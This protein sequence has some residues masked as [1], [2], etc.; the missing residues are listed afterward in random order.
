M[1]AQ[2]IPLRNTADHWLV[3]GDSGQELEIA[4][5]T[6]RVV[7]VEAVDHEPMILTYGLRAIPSMVVVTLERAD[8][9]VVV[10]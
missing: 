1:T 2:Q 5:A 3:P 9:P 4:D 7:Q 8:I 6:Y 10:Q